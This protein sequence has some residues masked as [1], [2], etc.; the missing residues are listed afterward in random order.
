MNT[1]DIHATI[2]QEPAADLPSVPAL[3]EIAS[4]SLLQGEREILIRH[5]EEVYR[6]KVTRNDKLI[7]QK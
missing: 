7:L 5:G 6:L 2:R 4:S 1:T 3:R